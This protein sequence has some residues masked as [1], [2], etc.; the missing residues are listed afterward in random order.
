MVSGILKEEIVMSVTMTATAASIVLVHGGF[1]DGSG[2]H[3][4]YNILK[5]DGYSVSIVQNPTISLGDDVSVTKRVIAA[6]AGPVILVGHSYG[7]AVITE[8]GNDPRVAALV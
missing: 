6:Q 8:A 4:V 5:K 1:V 3:G 2:W 7:G